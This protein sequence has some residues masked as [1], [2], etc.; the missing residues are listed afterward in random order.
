MVNK[1]TT[2]ARENMPGACPPW[3]AGSRSFSRSSGWK[4]TSKNTSEF[5]T[6]FLP[7]NDFLNSQSVYTSH[8]S[9]RRKKAAVKCVY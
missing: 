4:K 7:E 8:G 9:L 2:Y 5:H 1:L 3:A 6:G